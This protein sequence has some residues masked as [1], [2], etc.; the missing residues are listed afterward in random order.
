MIPL[1]EVLFGAPC[2]KNLCAVPVTIVTFDLENL[3]P[4]RMGRQ[5]SLCPR[6]SLGDTPNLE[7]CTLALE[8][9]LAGVLF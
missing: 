2:Q 3:D 7:S 8:S 4:R 9:H 6:W 5:L 1:K